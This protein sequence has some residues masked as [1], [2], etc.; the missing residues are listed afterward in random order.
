MLDDQ[1]IP[2]TSIVA[3]CLASLDDHFGVRRSS[4][5]QTARALSGFE[6]LKWVRHGDLREAESD[7]SNRIKYHW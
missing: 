4:F 6:A 3:S 1:V 2:V 5:N 7:A